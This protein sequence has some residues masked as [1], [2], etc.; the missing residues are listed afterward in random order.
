MTL[1][2]DGILLSDGEQNV[3]LLEFHAA[4]WDD[5]AVSA[6]DHHDQRAIPAT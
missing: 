3:T 4:I 1:F 6:F 5:D 2:I